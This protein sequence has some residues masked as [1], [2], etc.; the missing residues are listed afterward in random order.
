MASAIEK[1]V[2]AQNQMSLHW[3][4]TAEIIVKNGKVEVVKYQGSLWY[5]DKKEENGK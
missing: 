5:S 4:K 3:G 1:F 2:K